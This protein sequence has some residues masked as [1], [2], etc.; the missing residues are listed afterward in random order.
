MPNYV[1]S[2]TGASGV[3]YGIRLVEQLIK[4]NFKVN[5]II[6]ETSFSILKE[7]MNI[8]WWGTEEEIN[9]H[10]Q[11]Y[12]KTTD[13]NLVCFRNDNLLASVASGSKKTD[14]M[15]IMPCS[16]GTL[17]RIANGISSNLLERT[18]DVTLKERR[19]LIIVPR[20]TPLNMIHLQNMLTLSKMGTHIV[21]AVPAFYHQ[22][23][24][25]DDLINFV[26][27][28]VLDLIGVEHDN[29]HRWDGQLL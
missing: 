25:I 26:V 14:G 22:P 5:L 23:K 19:P 8:D 4:N 20:E 12:F 7:E 2:I 15:V 10:A 11:G 13:K 1:V 18:A 24:T 16:M 29:F 21:P 17:G 6:S 27:G 28:K 9:K 3:V